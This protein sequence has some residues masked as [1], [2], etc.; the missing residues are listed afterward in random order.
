MTVRVEGLNKVVRDLQK[1]GVEVADLKDVMSGIAAEGAKFAERFAP[2]RTGAL[3]RTV[4]G[5]KAKGKAVVMAGRARVPYAGPINYGW[6]ARNIKPAHFLA[7]ADAQL[8][9]VAPR[10]L[11]EGL[12]R[13]IERN[14]LT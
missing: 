3:A 4:R 10:M 11:Q 8:A 13:L 2:K 12:D 7:R 14:D 5:N 9:D 6:R 1:T